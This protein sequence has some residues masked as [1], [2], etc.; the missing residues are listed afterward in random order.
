MKS[1]ILQATDGRQHLRRQTQQHLLGWFG[2][3]FSPGRHISLIDIYC[4]I[5]ISIIL[6]LIS[7][8]VNCCPLLK[9][10]NC[11]QNR[12]R[13]GIRPRAGRRGSRRQLG[14]GKLRNG[15]GLPIG[16]DRF[17]CPRCEWRA[18]GI[19]SEAKRLEACPSP[20]VSQFK[21]RQSRVRS[22][23][24]GK[25]AKGNGFQGPIHASL[26]RACWYRSVDRACFSQL[27]EVKPGVTLAYRCCPSFA[28]R[29][30]V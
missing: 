10:A 27:P 24:H 25:G 26:R 13:L 16:A 6:Y 20:G 2:F 9:Y 4:E 11:I 28:G 29:N 18:I 1:C 19:R 22:L 23:A 7:I 12:E 3:R 15:M 21:F 30:A 5:L 14:C 8:I 17:A